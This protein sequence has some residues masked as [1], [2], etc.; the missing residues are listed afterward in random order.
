M[1]LL[2]LCV[3]AMASASFGLASTLWTGPATG[4]GGFGGCGLSVADVDTSG[5]F[6]TNT[7]DGFTLGGSVTLLIPSVNF[8]F[9]CNVQFLSQR[10]FN[11]YPGDVVSANSRLTGSVASTGN[12]SFR[13]AWV[14]SYIDFVA[15]SNVWFFAVSC[16]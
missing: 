12:L 10:S 11:Y 2:L 8:P 9:G 15:G 7:P 5:L 6:F 16:G 14:E 1:R 4:P 3:T 13:G